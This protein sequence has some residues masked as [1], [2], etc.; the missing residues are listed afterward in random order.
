MEDAVPQKKQLT[1]EQEAALREVVEH[2]YRVL[3]RERQKRRRGDGAEGGQ[4]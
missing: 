4:E 2:C 1:E 3:T